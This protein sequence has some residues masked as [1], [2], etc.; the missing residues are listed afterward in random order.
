MVLRLPSKLIKPYRNGGDFFSSDITFCFSVS[1]NAL[2]VALYKISSSK[3]PLR[4]SILRN[5]SAEF[6][7][8]LIIFGALFFS[9]FQT[10]TG[11]L[12]QVIK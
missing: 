1:Q 11:R 7:W 5:K 8:S 4:L 2:T 3:C 9:I 6:I 12:F 10:K